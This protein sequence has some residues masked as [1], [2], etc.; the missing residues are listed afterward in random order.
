MDNRLETIY[1]LIE[2]VRG[3]IDVGTDHGYLPVE[4]AK[5][6][7]TGHIFASDIRPGPLSVAVNNAERAGVSDKIRFLLCDGLD[8]CPPDEVDTIV[9]AGMGGDTICRVLDRAE[10]CMDSRYKLVL[11]P[12]TKQEVL[13]Y[14]LVNNE[15]EITQERLAEDGGTIYQ[16]IAARLGAPAKLCD[17]E[18]Y[19]GSFSMLREEALFTAHLEGLI[20]RFEKAAAGS[21]CSLTPEKRATAEIY[22][23]VLEKLKEE[24]NV[25]D[26]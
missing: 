25:N 4:L 2:G 24:L 23:A 1:S 7:Y 26:G 21:G 20:R 22:A 16:V 17:A 12:M 19:A 5:R 3:V 11:Q 15:M 6:G 13:R 14:W 10:W 18:L 9:V 8:A